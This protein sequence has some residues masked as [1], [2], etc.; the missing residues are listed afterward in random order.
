MWFDVWFDV[1][2]GIRFFRLL[3]VEHCPC[4]IAGTNALNNPSCV[5][6]DG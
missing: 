3:T 1:V 2:F 5:M 6:V 4:A